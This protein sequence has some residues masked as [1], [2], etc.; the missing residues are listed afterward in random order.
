MRIRHDDA[1]CASTGICESLAPELFEIGADGALVLLD[2]SPGQEL[3][4][5]AELAVSSC[6]TGALAILSAHQP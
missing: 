5:A 3:R 6:P 1:R 4:A 2:P